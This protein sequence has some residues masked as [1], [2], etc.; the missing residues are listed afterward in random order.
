MQKLLV[1]HALQSL[2]AQSRAFPVYTSNFSIVRRSSG[3][4]GAWLLKID[5]C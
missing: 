3:W 4:L 1:E 2:R 5:S